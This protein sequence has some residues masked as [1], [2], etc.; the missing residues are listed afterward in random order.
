MLF[1]SYGKNYTFIDFK[2]IVLQLFA[3]YNYLSTDK[4]YERRS[5]QQSI[6]SDPSLG[7]ASKGLPVAH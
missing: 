7:E 4:T 6:Y 1:P 3:D 5:K 2:R